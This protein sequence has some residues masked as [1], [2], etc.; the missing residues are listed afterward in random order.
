MIVTRYISKKVQVQTSCFL[1]QTLSQRC[2]GP[3]VESLDMLMGSREI[4]K[5]DKVICV[6]VFLIDGPNINNISTS[7]WSSHTPDITA[8]S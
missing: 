3:H 8:W 2:A 7:I 4:Y 6:H 1:C 5:T